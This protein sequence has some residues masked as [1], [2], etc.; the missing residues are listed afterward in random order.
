[1]VNPSEVYIILSALTFS[2]FFSG[3]EIAFVSADKLQ[4]EVQAKSGHFI[5]KILSGFVHNPSRFLATT[6]IGNNIALVVYG[7][8]MAKLLLPYLEL[9]LPFFIDN[10]LLLMIVETIISTILVLVTAEFLPKSLFLLNPNWMLNLLAIP[11]KVLYYIL[12]LP[13][14]FI[15]WLS[16][17]LIKNVLRLEYNDAKPV[18][19]LIDLNNYIKVRFARKS[20]SLSLS[21]FPI[22]IHLGEGHFG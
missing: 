22:F 13:T 7:I 15:A 4:I 2:A 5:S 11:M 17:G 1:M 8:F 18:Y 14:V 12:Y 3:I 6:L 10:Q 19:G 9:W 20:Y 16:K 21:T